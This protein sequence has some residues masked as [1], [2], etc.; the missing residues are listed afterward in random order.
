VNRA[1][2]CVV[3]HWLFGLLFARPQAGGASSDAD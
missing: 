1:L 3:F 2:A